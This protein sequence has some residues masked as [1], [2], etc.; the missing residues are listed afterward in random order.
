MKYSNKQVCQDNLRASIISYFGLDTSG[1]ARTIEDIG[2]NENITRYFYM[3]GSD[4]EKKHRDINLCTYEIK[5]DANDFANW[6]LV[7][8]EPIKYPFYDP[9]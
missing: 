2:E 7:S 1:Y 8:K 9:N 5:G 4:P 6:T 3:S